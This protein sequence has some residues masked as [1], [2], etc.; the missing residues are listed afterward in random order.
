MRCGDR[1]PLLERR[2]AVDPALSQLQAWLQ[3]PC[4]LAV[5]QGQPSV[6][7]HGQWKEESGAMD[8]TGALWGR[9]SRGTGDRWGDP[10]E[11]LFTSQVT[12][13]LRGD[14]HLENLCPHEYSGH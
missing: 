11:G 3:P 9:Y 7:A 5:L 1:C 10:G 13:E 4:G 2:A 12:C 8:V 6:W 14:L